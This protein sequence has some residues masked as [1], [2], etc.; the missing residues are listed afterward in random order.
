MA[1]TL[2][3]LEEPTRAL[4][5]SDRLLL[6]AD[7]FD[8]RYLQPVTRISVSLNR[9]QGRCGNLLIHQLKGSSHAP[10]PQQAALR[11]LGL[12]SRHA[13]SLRWS[14]DPVTSGYLRSVRHLVGVVYL[15]RPCYKQWISTEY[16][17]QQYGTQSKP[18]EVWRNPVGEYIG[19]ESD[20]TGIAV[21]M[22][23]GVGFMGVLSRLQSTEIDME[24]DSSSPDAWVSIRDQDGTWSSR[25]GYFSNVVR[26]VDQSLI[27]GAVIPIKT[28]GRVNRETLSMSLTWH[29]D[30]QKF[31]DIGRISHELGVS[32]VRPTVITATRY[33]EKYRGFR[34]LFAE[35]NDRDACP[36]SISYLSEGRRREIPL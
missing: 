14:S 9:V 35:I 7:N 22:S 36:V 32:A 21:Y 20:S 28:H 5:P 11:S 17:S 33:T 31:H 26:D 16:E 1:L 15:S 18:G 13:S 25:R 4:E 24:P 8:A 3:A 12:G 34:D 2:A 19:F 29:A 6:E 23:T 27:R 30:L 10:T